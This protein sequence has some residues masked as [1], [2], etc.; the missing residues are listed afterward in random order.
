MPRIRDIPL[1]DGPTSE[2]KDVTPTVFSPGTLQP[3]VTELYQGTIDRMFAVSSDLFNLRPHLESHNLEFGNFA[4]PVRQAIIENDNF[5]LSSEINDL[6]AR[7]GAAVA[8]D[9]KLAELVLADPNSASVPDVVFTPS[10]IQAQ[11]IVF[12]QGGLEWESA[13]PLF[14]FFTF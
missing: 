5:N 13:F 2:L 10:Q 1:V 7:E 14:P 8:I 3:L 4:A 6:V 12:Q 11:R 9:N